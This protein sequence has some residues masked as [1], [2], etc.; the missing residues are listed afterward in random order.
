MQRFCL[1][2]I[3]TGDILRKEIRHESE[4]GKQAKQIMSKGDLVPDD[5][6]IEMVS[7]NMNKPEC[8]HGAILDGFPRTANQARAFD[9]ILR[10]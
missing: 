4:L 1:C 9:E 7:Q 2:Q 8:S 3:S 6:V 5:I 10:K